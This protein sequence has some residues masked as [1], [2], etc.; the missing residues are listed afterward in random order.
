MKLRYTLLV[1]ALILFAAAC[2]DD[3]DIEATAEAMISARLTATATAW[4]ETPTPSDTPTATATATPTDTPTIT[5]SPTETPDTGATVEAGIARA[6]TATAERWTATPAPSDTPDT[7]ATVEAGIARALTAT[8]ERW[9]ATPVPSYTLPPSITPAPSVTPDTDATVEARIALALSATAE[10]WTATPTITPSPTVYL[11]PTPTRIPLADAADDDPFL[12]PADAPVVFVEFSD[13]QC[14]FCGNFYRETLPRILETY[15]D[16]VKFVYRDFTIFGEDSVRAA[17]ASECAAEQ[18]SFWEMHNAIFDL[19][20]DEE[21]PPLSEETLTGLASDVVPDVDAW[22]ECLQ[23]NRYLEEI[24]LDYQA[25]ITYGIMGTPGFVI[26]GTL[27]AIGAQPFDV[28]DQII[29]RE[30]AAVQSGEFDPSAQADAPTAEPPGPSADHWAEVQPGQLAYTRSG[31]ASAQIT[32]QTSTLADFAAQSGV[33]PPAAG[34]ETPIRDVLAGVR[35]DLAAQVTESGLTLGDEGLT[36]PVTEDFGGV[37]ISS[38]RLLL[39]PQFDGQGR[40]FSGVDLVV[41]V[42]DLGDGQV[43][44]V[45]FRAQGVPDPAIYADFRAWM[46]AN[47]AALAGSSP[48]QE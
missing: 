26:N 3:P 37:P 45:Q 8:A 7:G 19:M 22:T 10:G 13:F 34:S 36:G 32:Y 48:G 44:L 11:S 41:A 40:L 31:Q 25:A 20:A 16:T 46:D 42:L 23:S 17:Q 29:Q 6:L 12:G 27:Y 5:P 30:L 35:D 39:A 24:A 38:V 21:H 2:G 18:D 1:L 28:F 4:T 15:P 9:T 47:A 33:E 43:M 14:G